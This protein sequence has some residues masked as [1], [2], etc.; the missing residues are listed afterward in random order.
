MGTRDRQRTRR[1]LGRTVLCTLVAMGA[2]A[3]SATAAGAAAYRLDGLGAGCT[4][5]GSSNT[6]HG[7]GFTGGANV[8]VVLGSA[9]IGTLVADSDGVVDGGFTV[10]SNFPTGSTS[11]KLTGPSARGEHT[12]TFQFQVGNCSVVTGGAEI[13]ASSGGGALA[14]TGG[15][16]GMIVGISAALL[17][18]GGALIVSRRRKEQ[19]LREHAS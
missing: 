9:T 12:L 11:V 13:S 10:P 6:A 5:P 17:L 4:E 19:R 2:I 3:A 16:T 8:A 14:F 1:V 7:N 15:N 18:L